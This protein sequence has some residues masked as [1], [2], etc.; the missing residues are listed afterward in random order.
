VVPAQALRVQENTDLP[1]D[2]I[3]IKDQLIVE[4]AIQ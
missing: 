2:Q 4:V 3:D 1:A